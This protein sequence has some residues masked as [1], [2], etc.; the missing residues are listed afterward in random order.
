MKRLL[1][2]RLAILLVGVAS[3]PA[4]AQ[5]VVVDPANVLQSTLTAVRSLT[6]IQNQIQQLTNET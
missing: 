2:T 6:Q 1:I 4:R 3:L 5:W